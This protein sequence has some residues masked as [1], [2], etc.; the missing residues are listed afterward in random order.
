MAR[1][2]DKSIFMEQMR[3]VIQGALRPN[4]VGDQ[5]EAAS[6][7]LDKVTEIPYAFSRALVGISRC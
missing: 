3:E 1:A 7:V 5:D 6:H 2:F 4:R